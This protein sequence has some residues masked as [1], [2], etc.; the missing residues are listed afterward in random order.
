MVQTPWWYCSSCGFQNKPRPVT[1]SL[2]TLPPGH[3]LLDEKWRISH[4]E[5]CGKARAEGDSE[6]LP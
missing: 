2:G 5:Q 4:C 1:N 6:Y 3:Q